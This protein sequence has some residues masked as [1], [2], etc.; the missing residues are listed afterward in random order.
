MIRRKQNSI[1]YW[2][3]LAIIV[4]MPLSGWSQ[5]LL[6]HKVSLEMKRKP[7]GDVLKQ[8]G[9]QGDFH[10]SYNS[11]I[12]K[13]DSIVSV[14]AHDKTVRQVLDMLFDGKYEYREHNKHI[15]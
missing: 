3:I 13:K 9:A 12:I 2:F 5:G 1:V 8:I 7:L 11:N 10:F 4:L 6:G 15:I 14:S